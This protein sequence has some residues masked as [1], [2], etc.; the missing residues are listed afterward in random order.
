MP[1]RN[2][3]TKAHIRSEL[4]KIDDELELAKRRLSGHGQNP[5]SDKGAYW[6]MMGCLG[7]GGMQAVLESHRRRAARERLRKLQRQQDRAKQG[8]E[9]ESEDDVH[10]DD[11]DW[12]TLFDAFTQC[13]TLSSYWRRRLCLTLVIV[14]LYCALVATGYFLLL[15]PHARWHR[16][17]L[18]SGST[19]FIPFDPSWS[20]DCRDA[21]LWDPGP[22]GSVADML[23]ALQIHT[24][25]SLSAHNWVNN[26]GAGDGTAM[27]LRK[28]TLGVERG[29]AA[30][31]KA[32]VVLVRRPPREPECTA[33]D[34]VERETFAIDEGSYL[35]RHAYLTA[36]SAWRYTIKT[37]VRT[38]VAV[39]H[40]TDAQFREWLQQRHQAIGMNRV[41]GTSVH[42]G[43]RTRRDKDRKA[44]SPDAP[45]SPQ[46]NK[47]GPG[48]R[49]K[50]DRKHAAAPPPRDV[51][52]ADDDV[53]KIEAA[54]EGAEQFE[55][56]IGSEGQKVLVLVPAGAAHRQTSHV[57][58][59]EEAVMGMIRLCGFVGRCE[60]MMGRREGASPNEMFHVSCGLC[61]YHVQYT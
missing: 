38:P 60:W 28:R 30:S 56:R 50:P 1:D 39:L 10:D 7:L 35:A 40:F 54:H 61:L 42:S 48:S 37:H 43:T 57:A 52:S 8:E 25:T 55:W 14:L 27:R 58:G 22:L 12:S 31:S 41:N 59:A 11:F 34:L 44:I 33:S 21:L 3:M 6:R 23:R 32:K 18:Q 29:Q 17:Q 46:D 51:F 20:Q 26:V 45:L 36:G 53:V 9:S 24:A 4:K 16:L 19:A 5:E 47:R 13:L 2:A 15:P 49:S